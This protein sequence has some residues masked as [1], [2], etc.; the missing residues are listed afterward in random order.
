[1]NPTTKG[2]FAVQRFHVF[3]VSLE[4]VR[5]IRGVIVLVGQQDAALAGQL[6]RAVA[7]VPA[8]IAEG[9][10]RAGRDRRHL[11]R[12]AAGSADEVCA[13]LRVAEAWGY[14][15]GGD[16]AEVLA[17]ADRVLAMLWRLCGGRC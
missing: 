6:R 14:V 2:A 13:H 15:S 8:N 10:R 4:L 11:W 9:N 5:G 7:S 1:V 12:V 16:V 17:L 3:D